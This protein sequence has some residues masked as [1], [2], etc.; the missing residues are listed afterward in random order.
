[1]L[2]VADYQE[3]F[4]LRE[5]ALQGLN[6][7]LAGALK[8]TKRLSDCPG[9][10]GVIGQRREDNEGRTIAKGAGHL[11]RHS[12][13]RPG[14][15]VPSAPV[16]VINRAPASSRLTSSIS[17]RRPMKSVATTGRLGLD[18]GADTASGPASKP[19]AL[20]WAM[21]CVR[22]LTPSL[23]YIWRLYD[24]TVLRLRNNSSAVC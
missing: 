16:R 7:R 1:V 8:Q 15:P 11:L 4:A 12:Q 5:G 22:L 21:A 23:L 14:L 19:S 10:K 17:R 6:L 9:H 3:Q 18:G 2:E 13:R 20:A 24:L